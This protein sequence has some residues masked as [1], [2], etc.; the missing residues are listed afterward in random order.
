MKV[1]SLCCLDRCCCIPPE[2]GQKQHGSGCFDTVLSS[3][4]RFFSEDTG[5]GKVEDEAVDA[6]DMGLGG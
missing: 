3:S 4:R 2:Q 1:S 6:L 5:R